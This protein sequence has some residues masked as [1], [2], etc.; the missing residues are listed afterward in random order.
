MSKIQN[1]HHK[2]V[3]EK[4]KQ[5][6]SV[7]NIA[8]AY[9]VSSKTIVNLLIKLNVYTSVKKDS[10][11]NYLGMSIHN[12][13]VLS[14]SEKTD[15]YKR[16][17]L[18]CKCICNTVFTGNFNNIKTGKTKSCGCLDLPTGNKRSGAAALKKLYRSYITGANKRGYNFEL[19]LE[20]FERYVKSNCSY[21]GAKPSRIQYAY[22]KAEKVS[23]EFI[24]VNGIDRVDNKIG[25]LLSNCVP[26][27]KKCNT[28]KMDM[29]RKEFLTHI[30][31]ILDYQKE[32]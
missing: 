27:C 8:K 23:D 5:G 30:Q 2:D 19:S 11:K 4:Y 3:V 18:D 20:D 10:Y 17:Y 21:C 25:Y 6:E 29:S 31:S 15:S 7:S 9:Q 12:F 26:C 22:H 32:F 1:E 13:I 24:I 14:K 28:I 16:V